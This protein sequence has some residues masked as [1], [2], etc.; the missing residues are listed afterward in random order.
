MGGRK[1]KKEND[2]YTDISLP[3]IEK[4]AVACFSDSVH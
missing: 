1:P 3:R 2:V 4:E